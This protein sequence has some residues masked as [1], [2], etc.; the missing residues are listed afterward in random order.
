MAPRYCR[1]EVPIG[2][3][4]LWKMTFILRDIR[5]RPRPRF[6]RRITTKNEELRTRESISSTISHPIFGSSFGAPQSRNHR[7]S[8]TIPLVSLSRYAKI[9]TQ[10]GRDIAPLTKE[11]ISKCT[12]SPAFVCAYRVTVQSVIASR[13]PRRARDRLR[14]A[15]RS[16]DYRPFQKRLL[17]PAAL[18]SQLRQPPRNDGKSQKRRQKNDESVCLPTN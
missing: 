15:W 11:F 7:N 13:I 5:Y 9:G 10:S 4:D 3:I 8:S 12:C 1:M 14:E 17:R 16:L 18:R 6:K 2:N